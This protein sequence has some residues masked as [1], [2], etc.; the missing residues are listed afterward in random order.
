MRNI[1]LKQLRYF[2]AVATLGRFGRA[3][4]TCAISQPAISVQ[5][6][7]LEE[8]LGTQL[9]ERGARQVRLTVKRKPSVEPRTDGESSAVAG[10]E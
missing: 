3:A 9:F 5:I 2:D 6:R 4:E 10:G 1:T 8:S 7:D